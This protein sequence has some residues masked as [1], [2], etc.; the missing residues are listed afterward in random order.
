LKGQFHGRL[1]IDI[2]EYAIEGFLQIIERRKQETPEEIFTFL[3]KTDFGAYWYRVANNII[4][5][6]IKRERKRADVH[7]GFMQKYSEGDHS[8]IDNLDSNLWLKLEK[9]LSE[10]DFQ[11]LY[12]RGVEGATYFQIMN[13]LGLNTENTARIRFF[14]ARKKAMLI[15]AGKPT[16]Q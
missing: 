13:K 8:I 11:V 9:G 5:D 3:K 15:L 1:D 14:R 2:D 16:T 10:E 12:L 6:Y 7:D 4:I